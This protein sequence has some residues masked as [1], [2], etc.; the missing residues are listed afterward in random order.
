MFARGH[1]ADQFQDPSAIAKVGFQL[2]C[3]MVYVLHAREIGLEGGHLIV[4]PRATGGHRRWPIA[5]A[6]SAVTSGCFIASAN[7]RSHDRDWFAG[8][9]GLWHP[10]RRLSLWQ[11]S[12]VQVSVLAILSHFLAVGSV[13]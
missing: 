8:G 12:M 10:T 13:S 6:M 7:R 11:L 5:S 1:F 3:E 9:A 4:Q 2:C